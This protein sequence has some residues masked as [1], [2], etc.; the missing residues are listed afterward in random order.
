[1]LSAIRAVMRSGLRMDVSSAKRKNFPVPLAI[2]AICFKSIVQ[3]VVNGSE[4]Q[5][6]MG[7]NGTRTMTEA[8][9]KH[10]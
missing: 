9:A 1:M 2:C 10:A 7:V 3:D 6:T 4:N 5:N 8:I